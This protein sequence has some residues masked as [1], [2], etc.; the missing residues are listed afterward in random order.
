VIEDE[1]DRTTVRIWN[2]TG[3]LYNSLGVIVNETTDSL[4][5]LGNQ[6]TLRGVVGI[7]SSA[8]Q[9]LLGY[10]SDV[11][12]YVEGEA[13]EGKTKITVAP[14]PFVPKLGEVI[15]YTYEYPANCRAIIRVYDLSGRYIT[16][17]L[18]SYYAVSWKQEETW[19]GRNELNQLLAPGNY[20]L[21][22]QTTNRSTG[23]SKVS[24]A[25]V[26]IGVKF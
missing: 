10:A 11:E 17:L 21:H 22:L 6:V 25:P 3:A 16:T 15:K 13:G 23:K 12:P 5:T 18:D 1:T 20:L 24:I 8:P 19:N 14:Y 26:V 7:Y 2:T 9:I 4:L